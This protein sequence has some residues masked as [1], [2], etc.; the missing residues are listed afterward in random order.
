MHKQTQQE[1]SKQEVRF[2]LSNDLMYSDQTLY[3]SDGPLSGFG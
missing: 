2:C 3:V 1:V